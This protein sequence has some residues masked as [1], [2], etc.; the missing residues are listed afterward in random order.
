MPNILTTDLRRKNIDNFL[1]TIKNESVYFCFS[2]P[3]SWNS[4]E[5]PSNP[6]DAFDI[7][8]NVHNDM[9]YA[10]RITTNNASYVIPNVP[11]TSGSIYQQYSDTEDLSILCR[12]KSYVPAQA[13]AT[14]LNGSVSSI[15][16]TD[17]GSG[18]TSA[19]AVTFSSG[20]ATAQ[21]TINNGS[22]VSISVL[23]GGSNYS[24]APTVTIAAPLPSVSSTAFDMK[25]MYV[26][27]DEM[28]VYKCISNNGNLTS[29]VKPSSTA[30]SGTFNVAGSTGVYTWKYMYTVS[31]TDTERFYTTNWIP[32]KTLQ[33]NDSSTQWTVQFN[34][35]R[36]T[37]NAAI[38]ATGSGFTS[39]IG[40]VDNSII[41]QNDIL[42]I[43]NEQ[44][45]VSGA[46]GFIGS[47]GIVVYRGYNSTTAGAT[48]AN[49]VVYDL[50]GRNHGEDPVAEL[51]ATNLMVKVRV[52]GNE[53]D[54]IVDS[55][56]YRQISIVSNPVYYG[57]VFF[58]AA[59]GSNT[60]QLAT[61]HVA[62]LS[63]TSLSYY[64]TVGKKIIILKGR[65]KG[66]IREISSYDLTNTVTLT[67][68]WDITPDTTSVYG[69]ISN[70]S[71]TNQTVILSLGTVTNGPFVA[72]ST[73]TQ[74]TTNATG[75]VVKYDST[76]TPKRLYLTS[77]TGTFNG[78]NS[79]SSGSVSS[80][81]SAVTSRTLERN[82]GDVL[83]LE[84]RK[85]ITRYSD[86]IE[87]I[88]V[89]VKY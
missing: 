8:A 56:E 62:S 73:V 31:D 66:Q 9:L 71:V 70:A 12:T 3:D 44:V 51:N 49:T 85:P 36:T 60:L 88:K 21:A 76:S 43:G 84:N 64:P 10:K 34:A 28:N 54:Q 41:S 63:S 39:T 74:S 89:I 27:T 17:G 35:G 61:A 7:N 77:T 42:L 80:T 23:G 58:A 40:V 26:I 86:Q 18:Y 53:G 45:R 67:T 65:G 50:T 1:N 79:V 33:S 14:I 75:K 46:T 38:G 4:T 83:Y 78:T 52:T 15:I 2:N 6:T 16:I 25:P 19:P 5:T 47:T 24:V 13:T 30:T 72:D 22:V 48:G 37:L 57:S 69:I 59:A 68:S 82:S 20:S 87:D 81:V 11:W 29:T 32:V 55:N